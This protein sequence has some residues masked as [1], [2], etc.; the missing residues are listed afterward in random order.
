M[1]EIVQPVPG[2]D[3]RLGFRCA[4]FLAGGFREWPLAKPIRHGRVEMTNLIG[5]EI[6]DY[7]S[8]P[9][10][11]GAAVHIYGKA[12]VRPGRKMGHVTT[13]FPD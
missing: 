10:I 3:Q 8:W 11:P 5:N 12:A 6:E 7:R 13:V 1:D 9:S 2:R 4:L